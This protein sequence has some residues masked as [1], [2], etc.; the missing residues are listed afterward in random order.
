MRESRFLGDELPL[1]S[2]AARAKS[3]DVPV[4]VRTS[5]RQRHDVI[6]PR[7]VVAMLSAVLTFPVV[8]GEH[9]LSTDLF[10]GCEKFSCAAEGRVDVGVALDVLVETFL[11]L[12]AARNCISFWMQNTLAFRDQSLSAL[13]AE[14]LNIVQA[15]LTHRLAGQCVAVGMVNAQAR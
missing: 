2:I 7:V 1:D 5:D 15:F 3:L 10:I 6:H 13:F 8:A 12:L 4:A 9:D 14:P 11:T